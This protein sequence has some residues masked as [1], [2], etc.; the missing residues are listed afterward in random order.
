MSR[1]L[2]QGRAM[3]KSAPYLFV[4]VGTTS[5]DALVVAVLSEEFAEAAKAKSFKRIVVQLGRGVPPTDAI[6]GRAA[7]GIRHK[8][9]G[10]KEESWSFELSGVAYEVYR[11][12][13]SIAADIDGAGAVVS[14][15]G[16]GSIFETLRA[17]KPLVVVVNTALADNHQ[18]ELAEA[19]TTPVRHLAYC[20]PRTLVP[21][22]AA[23][24]FSALR[25]LPPC[26]RSRF[27]AAIDDLMR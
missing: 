18:V 20:E 4:S 1:A 26:D 27:V 5:F 11:F 16:A 24:D 17:R 22:L 21:T 23:V 15:A 8:D 25:P 14:H 6:V 9:A 2:A 19:M 13:P 7:S 3:S 12:K 10:A